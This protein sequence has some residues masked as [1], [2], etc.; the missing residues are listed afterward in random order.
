MEKKIKSEDTMDV[1]KRIEER[2]KEEQILEKHHR[3]TKHIIQYEINQFL[4]I[5][6]DVK[7][8]DLDTPPQKDGMV[9]R[10][11]NGVVL[12]GSWKSRLEEYRL[13]KTN[14]WK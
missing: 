8:F 14:N 12:T 10:Y 6:E 4:K 2:L 5:N 11:K 13:K 9:T 1:A 7:L 3:R